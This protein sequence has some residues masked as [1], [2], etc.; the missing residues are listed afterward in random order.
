MLLNCAQ[1][2]LPFAADGDIDIGNWIFVY[3][4]LT[5]IVIL[6]FAY[7]AKKG[8]RKSG[9][10]VGLPARLAE[11]LYLFLDNLVTELMGPSGRRY[12][13][14]LM[15]LWSFIFVGNVFSL[16]FNQSPTA[17]WSLNIGMAIITVSYVQYEGIRTQGPVGHL[18]HFAGPKLTG[19]LIIISGLLFIIEIVSELMK[20]FSLSIRLYGNIHGGHL[21][22]GALNHL[23][24]VVPILGG[25]LLPIKFFTCVIQAFV[26]VILTATYLSLV[27]ASHGDD[28]EGD[29]ATTN[30]LAA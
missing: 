2:K 14:F 5:M 23:V 11:H 10:W 19:S 21:L 28:H 29:H 16:I 24:P 12:V 4:L 18:K 26:W 25:V 9:N 1:F 22:V 30:A 3:S 15:A 17:D 27:T 20:L 8:I 6:V 13:P 7:L